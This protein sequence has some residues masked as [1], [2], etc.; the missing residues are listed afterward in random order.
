[1]DSKEI[2]KN[3]VSLQTKVP[4]FPLG[5]VGLVAGSLFLT[6]WAINDLV[7][8]PAS[9]FG[10]L[11][12]GAG[13]WWF[14]KPASTVFKKPSSV[15]GWTKKC[16]EVLE[17]FEAFEQDDKFLVN[18]VLRNKNL[19]KILSSS[20]R[21]VLGLI[22][23]V[24]MN[25]P[26]KE[27]IQSL[28]KSVAEVETSS[29]LPINNRNLLYPEKFHKYDSIFYHLP[30]PLRA[31]DLLWLQEIPENQ[32]A[33]I[34]TSWHEQYTWNEQ[35]NALKSQ[36][37]KRWENKI[38]RLS[39]NDIDLKKSIS[40]VKSFLSR[41][42]K[43]LDNTRM[44]ELSRLHSEWQN[45]LEHLRREK[46]TSVQ[47][48][49]QWIVAGAVFASPV[50]TTDLLAVAVVNGLM[51]N[52]M[53]EIWSCKFK[54]EL[55][56]TVARQLALAALGQ[57]VVEW[58]GQALLSVAK[59]HGGTWIAAG[60]LQALSAAYLTRVVGSSMADWMAL[61][62]GVSQPDLDQLKLQANGLVAKA[63]ETE[64]VDWSKF[65]NNSKHWIKDQNLIYGSS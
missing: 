52:E 7:H 5:K 44:R 39:S 21:Q 19:D 40:P 1:M 56:K 15:K 48:R 17:E 34:V 50:P 31:I 11:A 35:Y 9:G 33:W 51:V 54:P 32:P 59:L 45:D 8:L 20:D 49:S 36:L 14:T 22:S 6:Q 41:T 12:A 29:T 58:S 62:N 57:G 13:L 30:L 37:P 18:S 28:V 25:L 2:L 64:K 10:V 63:M 60:T 38:L 46:F 47:T 43:N 4:G 23:T 42:T 61:N 53:S 24:G 16:R 26:E 65:I 27:S 55:L 3:S